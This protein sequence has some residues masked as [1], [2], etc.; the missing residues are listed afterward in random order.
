MAW[1]LLIKNGAVIDG[2][3]APRTKADVAVAGDKI[4]AVAPRLSGDAERTID[5]TNLI[6]APGFIDIHSHSDFFYEQ[7]PSAESKIRQGVTTEVVGMCSF[8]PAPVTADS[9]HQ[10]ETSANALGATLEVRWRSFA[11]YLDALE[12]VH[13]SINIVH[14]VGHGPIRYA[15][16]GGDKRAPSPAELDT[17]KSLLAEALAAGAFGLSSGLVYAPSAFAKTDELIALC[18][19]MA[20]RGGQY[21]THMRGE[22]PT[23]LDAVSEAVRICEEGEVPLQ[24]AHLK[25]SGR[26]NWPLFDRALAVI[27]AARGRGLDATADVYP[28]AASSTF[29]SALLPDWVH[30][31]G[32]AKALERIRDP[33]TRRRLIAENSPDGRWHAA[34]DTVDWSDI[35]IATCPSRADEG[36]TLAQL[37]AKRGKPGAEAMLD[38]LSEHDAAVSMVMFTQAEA[39]VQ[40]A[41]RQPYVMI[42]SDSLGLS[43]GPG[44][45]PGRPHPRMYGTFPRVLGKY[46]RDA[47]LFTHEQAVAKMTGQPAEKLKLRRRG[48]VRADY[49]ADLTLFDPATVRDEATFEDPHR[50][51]TGIPCVIVNGAVV[52]DDG[53]FNARPAGRVLGRSSPMQ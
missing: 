9:R 53:R 7:C 22:G 24:I 23:L 18:R 51:P 34:Q 35:M 8:S 14:F 5:A 43:H 37:A 30:D 16:M 28:Y 10:V 46:A 48:S 45:H 12:R 49:F 13:P 27:D 2:S 44:P 47:G 19:S 33:A 42:G 1:S 38:L 29:L 3:G 11:Q 25:S 17:M 41:L 4:V 26:A 36:S 20:G 32:I 50:Y 15:A 6:V 40:K 31:G 52:V 39:N 21:F